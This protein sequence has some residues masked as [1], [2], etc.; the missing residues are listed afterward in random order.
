M[1]VFFVVP[2]YL[3]LVAFASAG[4]PK[5]DLDRLVEPLTKD[6]AAVGLVV[7]LWL[8]GKPHVYG[9][10]KVTT[11]VGEME[12]DGD[13][14]FEIG[15]ITKALTGVLL[16]DAVARKELALDDPANKHLPSDL[17]IKPKSDQTVTLLHLATHRSGLPVQP[18]FVGLLA[19]NKANPYADFVRPK[20]VQL[21]AGLKPV[22]EPGTK[23]E[24]SNLAAGLLGHALAAT[25]KADSYDALVRERVC[26]PLGL[27]DTGEALTG[28]QK[29]RLARGHNDE[30]QPTDPWEFAT[31]EACGGLRSSANDLLRFAAANLGEVKT[32]LLEVLKSSHQKRDL[33]GSGEVEV[34]LLWHRSK[35]KDGELAVWHN[36]GTGG[37]RSMLAFT[38]E[39]KR[40]VVVLCSAELGAKVDRLAFNALL[41]LQPK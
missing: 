10:G 6:K 24:Y 15:S 21:M 4:D 19:R 39:T 37:Y 2:V 30:L 3:F 40:A 9:Y 8:D 29:A 11:A 28:A 36:G 32:P 13:T 41:Q 25:A 35:L 14:L 22:R 23:Y 18:P 17:Q 33:A 7:G 27:K 38:P 34:G 12:P 1:R 5:P 20:L 16:A 31:L 26:K